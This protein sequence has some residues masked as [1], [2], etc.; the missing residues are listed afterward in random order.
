MNRER[1][2]K[3]YLNLQRSS[4]LNKKIVLKKYNLRYGYYN[5]KTHFVALNDMTKLNIAFEFLRNRDEKKKRKKCL[6][7]FKRRKNNDT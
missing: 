7:K 2:R 1:I 6:K 3:I 5:E 4:T